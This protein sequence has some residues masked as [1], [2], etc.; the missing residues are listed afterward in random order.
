MITQVEQILIQAKQAADKPRLV[1]VGAENESSL[2]A[3]VAAQ[4]A[5]LA[6]VALVGDRAAVAAVADLLGVDIS[7]L[8]LIDRDNPGDCVTAALDM[9]EAGLADVI[10][11]GQVTTHVLLRGVLNKKYGLRTDRALSHTSV[12]N[13]PGEDRVLLVTD[14][15]VNVQPDLQ[16]KRDIIMN[17]VDIAHALG[18]DRPKVAVMSFVEEVTDPRIGSL[19]DAK[20]L[21]GMG[22]DGSIT[23]C[24][25]EGPYSL[26]VALSAEAAR[27]KGIDSEV[28]GRADIIVMNDI[29][30]G[31]ILYKALLL[32]VKPTIASI[33][34]GAKIPL[35]VPSR[36]DT[37]A[38]KFDSIA[39]SIL[40]LQHRQGLA[41]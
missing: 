21:A 26:D 37:T 39:L 36:A 1:L 11:K 31:N 18:I 27:I 20:R 5:G 4:A 16:R 41:I 14:T 13:V 9:V 25:I 6:E 28:A 22:R 17:A 40:V 2:A 32:W 24:V 10:V 38:S 30:M 35:V 8:E 29:G 19:V 23:G 7:P 15:G 3:A 33:V 12:F 34:L